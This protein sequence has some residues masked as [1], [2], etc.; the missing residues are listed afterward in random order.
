ML[1]KYFYLYLKI[2][3]TYQ[4]ISKISPLSIKILHIYYPIKSRKK[5]GFWQKK[6]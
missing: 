4:C 3:K 5:Q 1:Q 2:L 6:S